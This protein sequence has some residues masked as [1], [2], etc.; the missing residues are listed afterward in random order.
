MRTRAVAAWTPSDVCRSVAVG[1]KGSGGPSRGRA[2]G[3][4]SRCDETGKCNGG[5]PYLKLDCADGKQPHH[6]LA[7]T[8]RLDIDANHL[9]NRRDAD[10]GRNAAGR[11][12]GYGPSPREHQAV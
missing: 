12:L 4:S 10:A 6:P 2:S 8:E 11:C 5:V 9:V 1:W 3:C 7:L